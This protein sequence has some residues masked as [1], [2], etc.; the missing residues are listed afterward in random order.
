MLG[1]A[2][3]LR[4]FGPASRFS[5]L[6]WAA[7]RRG[8]FLR[9]KHPASLCRQS[10]PHLAPGHDVFLRRSHDPELGAVADLDHIIAAVTEKY[11]AGHDR[12]ED[13]MPVAG[14]LCAINV[15]FMLPDRNGRVTASLKPGALARHR[16]AG[17]PA[18][19]G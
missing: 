19:T 5:P 10:Q 12:R 8:L 7:L 9:F 16:N 11:V 4:C 13:I 15:D 14:R 2:C 6:R 1:E 17:D 18:W 3:A